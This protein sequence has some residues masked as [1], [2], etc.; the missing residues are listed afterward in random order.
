MRC[1]EIMKTQV[2][3]VR[4]DD[5]VAVAAKKMGECNVGFLPVCDDGKHVVCTITDRDLAIRVLGERAAPDTPVGKV[6]TREVGACRPG[7]TLEQAERIMAEAQKSRILCTDDLGEL[8]GVIS[9]SDLAQYDS[10]EQVAQ[11]VREVTSR[12]FTA[13]SVPVQPAPGI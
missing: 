5:E 2:E 9:L 1:E 11:I 8:V 7:D 10:D 13:P 3:C 4:P 12:E 6:M